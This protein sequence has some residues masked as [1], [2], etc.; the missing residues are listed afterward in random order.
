MPPEAP[1]SGRPMIGLIDYHSQTDTARCIDSILAT[2]AEDLDVVVVVNG[3]TFTSAHP[4]V[5]TIRPDRNLGFAGGC[6]LLLT[7]AHDTRAPWLWVLNND[8]TLEE[9]W[10]QHLTS[11]LNHSS[12]DLITSVTLHG[13]SGLVWFGGGEYHSKTN[14]QH[15]AHYG[16]EI[17]ELSLPELSPTVW[18][19][20]A[21]IVVRRHVLDANLPFDEDLFLYR[22]EFDW[23]RANRLTVDL[24]GHP[25]VRHYPGSTTGRTAGNLEAYFSARNSWV[26]GHRY[27]RRMNWPLFR[28]VWLWDFAIKPILRRDW[29]AARAAYLGWRN[30]QMPGH[31]AL[32]FYVSLSRATTEDTP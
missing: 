22:E 32:E 27:L 10:P 17:S 12:A 21:N 24:I 19:S 30:R 23:Q 9:G 5:R 6:N 2:A 18:A 1:S 29:T 15:H 13:D 16:E 7:L 8:C 4:Q 3:G 11:A 14:R 25:L 31:A 26:T 20:G 28:V